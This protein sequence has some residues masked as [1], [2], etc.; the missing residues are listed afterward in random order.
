MK[1]IYMMAYKQN[2]IGWKKIAFFLQPPQMESFYKFCKQKAGN[3]DHKYLAEHNS[4]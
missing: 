2:F 3:V 4:Y 1:S